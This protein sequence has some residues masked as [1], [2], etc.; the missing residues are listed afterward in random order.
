MPGTAS[1]DDRHI[2]QPVLATVL[3][4][5]SSSLLSPWWRA[6]FFYAHCLVRRVDAAPGAENNWP[7]HTA[8]GLLENGGGEL[9]RSVRLPGKS[10]DDLLL[11]APQ[12]SLP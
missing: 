1:R 7:W 2:L 5:L 11:F 12:D 8:T 3:F 9:V 10:A 6:W 4:S